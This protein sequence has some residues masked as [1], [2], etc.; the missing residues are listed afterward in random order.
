ML[1]D[2]IQANAFFYL[3][4][5]GF[6]QHVELKLCQTPIHSHKHARSEHTKQD[7]RK[8]KNMYWAAQ[9]G[10]GGSQYFVFQ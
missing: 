4:R 1:V 6:A 7:E 2:A 5:T 3:Y 8:H 10:G 9:L